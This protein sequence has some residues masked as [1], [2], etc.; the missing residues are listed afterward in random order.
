M[1]DIILLMQNFFQI[2]FMRMVI[3]MMIALWSVISPAYS[4]P[5]LGDPSANVLSKNQE[6][7][8]GQHFMATIRKSVPLIND[9]LVNETVE[10][11][12]KRLV[13][14][15]DARNKKF[16]F[17]VIGS[18]TINAVSGFNANVGV[19]A[20][21]IMMAKNESEL[22]SVLAH[23]ISHVSQ[24]H[25]AR[26]MIHQKSQSLATLTGMVAA[27][28]L[29]AVVGGDMAA[30]GMMAATSASM[31]NAIAF[32]REFEFEADRIGV[33]LLSK[34]GYDPQGM[35]DFMKRMDRANMSK[36]DKLFDFLRTHPLTQERMVEAEYRVKKI[37]DNKLIRNT[38]SFDLLQTRVRVMVLRSRDGLAYY[39][40]E[41]DKSNQKGDAW[42]KTVAKYGYALAEILSQH[43][44]K[45]IKLM[46][47]LNQ[48]YPHHRWFG[49]G[50]GETYLSAKQYARA[51]AIFKELNEL[52]PDD[53][54]IVK[55]Y[56]ECLIFANKPKLAATLL[57][58]HHVGELKDIQ[59][60][61]LYAQAQGKSGQRAKA[62]QIRAKLLLLLGD[63][64][65]ARLQYQ[66]ALR[67]PEITPRE[68]LEINEQLK[69]FKASMH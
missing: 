61:D 39:R 57:A 48:Q 33:Q 58:S 54:A 10:R 66:Q 35:V 69:K 25:L 16:H 41:M 29:G 28:A 55:Y 8:L 46:S 31:E 52:Y 9:P 30:G 23:E 4:L 45:A 6:Q 47:E 67:M 20:G 24:R 68:R 38:Q 26:M 51:L 5:D 11:I 14:H 43:Y 21:T 36:H 7:L 19:N 44:P 60:L 63:K 18:D 1:C 50:L 64:R 2:S 53:I 62:Y 3:I 27:I 56:A 37:K 59:L 17:F 15:S 42:S 13:S 22:A 65:R 12:G 34:A 49:V 32:S 40:A